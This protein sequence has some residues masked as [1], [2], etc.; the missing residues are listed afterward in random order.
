[1]SK[2]FL[3][4][5]LLSLCGN[6]F[7]SAFICSSVSEHAPFI[8]DSDSDFVANGFKGSGT[9]DDPY[10]IE[11]L[12]ILSRG[13]MSNAIEVRNTRAYFI[14][15]HCEIKADYIGI[16][17]DKVAAGTASVIGN[18]ITGNLNTGGGI[19][20]GANGVRVIDNNC[21]GLSEGI[22]INYAND[23]V[24]A[25]NHLNQNKYHGLS[26]RYSDGNLIVNNTVVG[27][28]AHGIFVIRSSER[29]QIYN[30]TLID[31]ANIDSYDWDEIYHFEVKSQALDEGVGNTWY[32]EE[33]KL[34]NRWSDYGGQ[35]EYK[36]DGSKNFVD[37]YPVKIYSNLPDVE[38]T[39]ENSG[40]EKVFP[41]V[42][43]VAIV[44]GFGLVIFL[45]GIVRRR[46][47]KQTH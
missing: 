10:V 9:R 32:N 3:F 45:L 26:I 19:V 27:N 14:I 40:Q 6:L 17:I 15:L 2:N 30:N 46:R 31:N 34:G 24:I 12:H 18:V 21:T 22:H 29:N 33:L 11:G 7:L 25:G 42:P 8:I 39:D 5:L 43:T 36:I 44:F 23:C 16:L 4:I 28:G 13:N 37:K 20:L 1:M 47:Q 38:P 41:T 35:G